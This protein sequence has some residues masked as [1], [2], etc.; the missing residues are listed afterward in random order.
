MCR[1]QNHTEI[2]NSNQ[3]YSPMEV[4]IW[5]HT[6]SQSRKTQVWLNWSVP[7]FLSNLHTHTHTHKFPPSPIYVALSG[8]GDVWLTVSPHQPEY[9]NKCP[10]LAQARARFVLNQE[11]PWMLFLA[12]WGGFSGELISMLSLTWASLI[13][14]RCRISRGS[15]R[16]ISIT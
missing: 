10:L 5:S 8:P 7:S 3:M 13:E 2:I 1:Q 9:E 14:S 6:Q 4:W 16:I 15:I 11:C 12:V